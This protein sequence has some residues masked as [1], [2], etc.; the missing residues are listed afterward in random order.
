MSCFFWFRLMKLTFWLLLI[1]CG[2]ALF[3]HTLARSLGFRLSADSMMH[4]FLRKAGLNPHGYDW[5]FV[6]K[7]ARKTACCVSL[8]I[9]IYEL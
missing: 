7:L 8:A 4:M 2:V 3:L 1:K 5:I 6:T 9:N